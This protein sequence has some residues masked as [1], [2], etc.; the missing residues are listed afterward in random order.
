MRRGR[1]FILLALILLVG[2]VAAFFVLQPPPAE[3]EVEVAPTPIGEAEIVI[4]AQHISRG[5]LIPPEAVIVSPYP[6]DYK[7]ETMLDDL[8]QVVGKRARMDIGRG[9]PITENMITDQAGDLLTVG[10]DASIAIP[11]GFTAIAIPMDRFSGVAFALREG[12]QVDVLVSMLIVD[13]DTD[14]QSELPN[15]AMFLFT[16]AGELL[17]AISCRLVETTETGELVCSASEER[18]PNIGLLQFDESSGQDFYAGP[19]GPQRPRLVTQRMITSATVLG[20]G[21]FPLEIEEQVV[22]VIAVAEEEGVGAPE[23]QVQQAG[24]EEAPVIVPPDIITLI[25]TPQDALAIQWAV[26]AGLDLTLTL[27][28]PNDPTPE[29]DTDSVTLQFLIDNYDIAVPSKLPYGTEPRLTTEDFVFPPDF[30]VAPT[31]VP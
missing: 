17:S 10:S 11:Q 5:S 13:L 3:P 1:V 21:N 16:S 9:V 26:N 4:A 7:V 25:V 19:S 28:S 27:R 23:A 2:A 20:V 29:I 18:P 12:D 15:E 8:G 6:A 22:T 24:V 30:E 14:F 31:P